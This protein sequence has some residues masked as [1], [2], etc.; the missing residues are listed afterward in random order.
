[1]TWGCEDARR[2]RDERV[3]VGVKINTEMIKWMEGRMRVWER[4]ERMKVRERERGFE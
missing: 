3:G 1:M 4:Q 2:R